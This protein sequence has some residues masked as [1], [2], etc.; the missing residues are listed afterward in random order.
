[1]FV[2]LNLNVTSF[3]KHLH[4][5]LHIKFFNTT[6]DQL[7]EWLMANKD[8]KALI[9]DSRKFRFFEG[10]GWDMPELANI[11]EFGITD[12]PCAWSR[13]GQN[14]GII[15]YQRWIYFSIQ[16]WEASA[17]RQYFQ[18]ISRPV[19]KY[20]IRRFIERKENTKTIICKK[21]E[22]VPSFRSWKPSLWC[23]L[24]I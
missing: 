17:W 21:K 8:L 4:G 23:F 12:T 3:S 13:N 15:S 19:L 24:W 14:H 18:R 22:I 1:M 2:K 16:L 7:E 6:R 20:L 5:Q 11:S 10:A 9:K